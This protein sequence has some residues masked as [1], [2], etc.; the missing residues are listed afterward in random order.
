MRVVLFV[1]YMHIVGRTPWRTLHEGTVE[2]KEL[3][4]DLKRFSFSYFLHWNTLDSTITMDGVLRMGSF[5]II[6]FAVVSFP[7]LLHQPE[8]LT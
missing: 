6:W 1:I 4:R 3:L 8:H 5:F 2:E 7:D